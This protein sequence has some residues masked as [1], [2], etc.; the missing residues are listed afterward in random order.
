MDIKFIVYEIQ[1]GLV[2]VLS[3]KVPD[4][5]LMGGPSSLTIDGFRRL[6]GINWEALATYE[7]STPISGDFEEFNCLFNVETQQITTRN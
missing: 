5:A 7:F 3:N 4:E 2:I 1:S 6:N